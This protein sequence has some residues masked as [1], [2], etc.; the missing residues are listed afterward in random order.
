[1]CLGCPTAPGPQRVGVLQ[2]RSWAPGA[3]AQDGSSSGGFIPMLPRGPPS[4]VRGRRQGENDSPQGR[5]Q[6][7]FCPLHHA[8]PRRQVWGHTDVEL[9]SRDGHASFKFPNSIAVLNA[10]NITKTVVIPKLLHQD[11]VLKGSRDKGL[12]FIVVFL[13]FLRCWLQDPFFDCY[14]EKEQLKIFTVNI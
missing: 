3:T 2:E 4:D 7:G 11:L 1:M 10:R 5:P 9:L 14:G 6:K 12:S 8:V 13:S